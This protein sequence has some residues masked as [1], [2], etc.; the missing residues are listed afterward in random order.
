M[1]KYIVIVETNGTRRWYN[2]SDQLHR[3]DGPAVEFANGSKIWCQNGK[4]HR[5]DGPAEDFA[6][7][8]KHWYQNGKLHRT[9]GPALEYVNGS[10]FWYIEGNELTEAEFLNR[11]MAKALCE[12][13]VVEVDGVRYKLVAV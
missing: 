5:T 7:G 8:D 4:T 2:E 3:I 12:D 13:K 10:K 11:T 9:D 6:N 1:T